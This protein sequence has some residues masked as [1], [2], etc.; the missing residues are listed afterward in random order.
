M[1]RWPPLIGGVLLNLA[2]G[3]FYAWSVFILPLEKAFGWG[4]QQTSWVFTIVV[5]VTVA[6]FVLGGRMQDTHGPR[7]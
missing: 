3:A 6:S 4:C 5:I 7:L 2:L 1:K